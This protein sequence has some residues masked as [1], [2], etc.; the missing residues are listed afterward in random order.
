M[1]RSFSYAAEA[2]LLTASE[3]RPHPGAGLELRARLWEAGAASAFLKEYRR[4]AAQGALAP[5]DDR[6]FGRLL[7]AFILDKALYEVGYELASRPHWVGVPLLGILRILSAPDGEVG[8][9]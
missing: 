9:R 5:A 1:L 3:S 4:T 2:A 6:S 7:N 8:A